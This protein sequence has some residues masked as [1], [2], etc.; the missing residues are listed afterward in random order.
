[1]LQRISFTDAQKYELCLYAHDNKETYD[2]LIIEKA[3]LLVGKLKIPKDRLQ[4][5]QGWLQKFKERNG[6]HQRI[7][8]NEEASAD[9]NAIIEWLLNQVEARYLIQDLKINIL[10]AIQFAIKGTNNSE[11]DRLINVLSL[12]YLLNAIKTDE[13]LILNNKN[14]IYEVSPDDQIIKKLAYTFKKNDSVES[15]NKNILK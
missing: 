1:M 7:L 6:I 8:H 10:Q 11:L 5:S 2:V 12:H 15:A 13:F 3:K 4:F 9:Q 14:I